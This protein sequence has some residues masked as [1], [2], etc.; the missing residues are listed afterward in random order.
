MFESAEGQEMNFVSDKCRCGRHDVQVIIAGGIVA[1]NGT[2]M[3]AETAQPTH[4]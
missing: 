4:G 1:C 2:R 3:T